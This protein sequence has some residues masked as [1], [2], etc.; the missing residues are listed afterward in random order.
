MTNIAPE[1]AWVVKASTAIVV[2]RLSIGFR[3]SSTYP[4]LLCSCCSAAKAAL[5]S[6]SSSVTDHSLGRSHRSE[7]SAFSNWPFV[8]SHRGDSGTKK[9]PMARMPG[10]MWI[11]P[12]GMM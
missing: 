11:I 1:A 6:S 7:R 5:I 10:T 9:S 8:A 4:T 3:K 12:R 2:L